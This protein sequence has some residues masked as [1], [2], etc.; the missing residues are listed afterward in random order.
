MKKEKPEKLT[1][2]DFRIMMAEGGKPVPPEMLKDMLKRM[3]EIDR[4][5]EKTASPP[6]KQKGKEEMGD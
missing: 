3:D 2:Q 1:P 4:K 5:K 6:K